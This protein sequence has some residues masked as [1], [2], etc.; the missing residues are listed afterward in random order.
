MAQANRDL[1]T[2]AAR[3]SRPS[4][5]IRDHVVRAPSSVRSATTGG[6]PSR[7]AVRSAVMDVMPVTLLPGRLRL[8]TRPSS[9]GPPA[10]VNTIGIVEVAALAV[11]ADDS[12]P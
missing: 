5:L 6:S 12:A 3:H 2:S 1:T 11:A 7:F 9:A 10:A 4:Q 8:G